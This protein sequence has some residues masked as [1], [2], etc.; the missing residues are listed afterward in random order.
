M[1]FIRPAL[2]AV[3]FWC[4]ST[5]AVAAM[6]GI[7]VEDAYLSLPPPMMKMTAG[8]LEIQNHSMHDVVLEG[9][10]TPA[11]GSIEIHHSVT[12]EDG[13]ARME[14]VERLVIPS[15]DSVKLAPGGYHLMVMALKEMLHAGQ[16]IPL[17]LSFTGQ[18]KLMLE[19][20][21][22]DLRDHQDDQ[23]GESMHHHHH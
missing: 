5:F 21:V 1:K 3:G 20:E 14:K 17:T 8:Y 7:H 15:H 4:V 9:V 18:K 13:V 12:D 22:R 6:D 2:A 16:K 11:A 19:A 23:M 10:S